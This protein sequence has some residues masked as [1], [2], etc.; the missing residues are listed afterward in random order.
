MTWMMK[1]VGA[2]LN[3]SYHEYTKL[4]S[5]CM[6]VR[7]RTRAGICSCIIH[8]YV[9]V[10]SIGIYNFFLKNVIHSVLFFLATLF[11]PL[12]THFLR[13][14]IDAIVFQSSLHSITWNPSIRFS[15]TS[16]SQTRYA[17]YR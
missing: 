3:L 14:F 7:A 2:D 10:G 11:Q 17:L 1:L 13:L 12:Y 16:Y 4:R 9:C 15:Q 6:C 8:V 5:I